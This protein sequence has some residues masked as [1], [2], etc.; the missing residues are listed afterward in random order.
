MKN[1]E[2]RGVKQ[3]EFD[4]I[5]RAAKKKS[6]GKLTIQNAIGAVLLIPGFMF[7]NYTGYA[8]YVGI[9]EK[10]EALKSHNKSKYKDNP[11]YVL[12][13]K[14]GKDKFYLK[15]PTWKGFK[16]TDDDK[17]RVLTNPAVIVMKLG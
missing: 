11:L 8:G 5:H 15:T 13:F 2:K 4:A 14:D 12:D 17:E 7:P 1:L 10:K 9:V 6:R 3:E 16:G